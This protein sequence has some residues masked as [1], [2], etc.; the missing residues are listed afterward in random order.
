MPPSSS[1]AATGRTVTNTSRGMSIAVEDI[2][3]LRVD[4]ASLA[5][6][7]RNPQGMA[8]PLTRF[9]VVAT[10]RSDGGLVNLAVVYDQK[11]AQEL[12]ASV[13]AFAFEGKGGR[14]LDLQDAAEP[15]R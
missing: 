1:S 13:R 12:H 4:D 7:K 10:R 8:A 5:S 6:H 9:H 11:A 14:T 15:A 3:I 2:N